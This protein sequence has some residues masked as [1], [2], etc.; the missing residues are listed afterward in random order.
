M[1]DIDIFKFLGFNIQIINNYY[2][3][4]GYSYYYLF[5]FIFFNIIIKLKLLLIK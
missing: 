2:Y 3:K 5:Y 1:S 4:K